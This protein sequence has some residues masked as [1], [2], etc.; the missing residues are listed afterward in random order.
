MWSLRL[1]SI[2][3]ALI[4]G[5]LSSLSPAA[6]A[7][8]CVSPAA[9][10]ATVR[11]PQAQVTEKADI[12]QLEPGEIVEREIAGGDQH[13]YR[14]VLTT[15][16][17]A[18][19]LITKQGTDI[20]LTWKSP[21]EETLFTVDLE[22]REHGVERISLL[23]K[24]DGP[25]TLVIEPVVKRYPR[26]H[27]QVKLD[28]LHQASEQD[29]QRFTAQEAFIEA[30]QR[31][32]KET[33]EAQGEA[34][35]KLA[36]ALALFQTIGDREWEARVAYWMGYIKSPLNKHKEAF[37][38]L[39]RAL[40][41][42]RA[43]G[44]TTGV[45]ETL[46][47]IGMVNL[48]LSKPP[49]ALEYFKQALDLQKS[50]A[51]RG[52][53][54]FTYSQLG[55]VYWMMGD[56]DKVGD[57]FEQGLQLLRELGNA[58]DESRMLASLSFIHMTQGNYLTGLEY[59]PPALALFRE[60]KDLEGEA[61]ALNSLGTIYYNLGEWEEKA[62]VYFNQSLICYEALQYPRNQAYVLTNLGITYSTLGQ[63]EKELARSGKALELKQ[64]ALEYFDRALQLTRKVNNARGE[65]NLLRHIGQVHQEMGNWPAALNHFNQTLEL[66]RK[67]SDPSTEARALKGIGEVYAAQG[68]R[69]K[70]LEGI[71]RALIIQR[72]I[73]ERSAVART[74]YSLARL[75]RDFGKLR[76]AQ[77]QIEEALDI[78]ESL[79][80]NVPSSNLRISFLAENQGFYDFYIDIL[81]RLDGQ[82]PNSG[83][84]ALALQASERAR[85]KALLESLAEARVDI[86]QGIAPALLARERDIHQQLNAKENNRIRLESRNA[87]PE[88]ITAADQDV[89]A[90]LDALH[91]VQAQ[92]RRTSP[93]Y[94]AITQPQPIDLKE[95]QA[96]LDAGTLLLV[97][98]LGANRS[99][100]WAVT[101][102]TLNSYELPESSHRINRYATEIADMIYQQQPEM[103][104]KL[105]V[106]KISRLLL[107]PVA[108]QLA[109][110]RLVIV[111]DGALQKLPFAALFAPGSKRRLIVEH[112]VINLPSVSVLV[113]LRQPWKERVSPE[114]TLV[115]IADPV[116][117]PEDVRFQQLKAAD[118]RGPSPYSNPLWAAQRAAQDVGLK[119][120]PRLEHSGREAEQI[121]KFIPPGE[122]VKYLGFDAS[123]ALLANP[124]LSKYR[125]LHFATH[126]VNNDKNPELSGIVLSLY[127]KEGRPQDGFLRM[128][129][130]YN[131]KLGAEM[132]VLSACK[133]G[134]GKQIRGEGSINLTRGIM[135]AGVPRIIVSLWNVNDAATAEL[136]KRF[137]EK[138][139]REKLSPAAA[140]RAAQVAMAHEDKWKAPYYWAGFVLQGEWR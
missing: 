106:E 5:P 61:A 130:F 99:F 112:E 100:L 68:D 28:D 123:R 7:R 72:R 3:I 129:E 140:L 122:Y 108:G 16:Q 79:R 71:D 126:S 73:K 9:P 111:A 47:T 137:Y 138:M 55:A 67:Q 70:A 62:L 98:R 63:R 85:A 29:R 30:V 75:E 21:T 69:Q 125:I 114:K 44:D 50:S 37:D 121:S 118:A 4:A 120:F 97:Y 94:A 13:Q 43:D 109:G 81:M 31:Y 76:E 14:L 96:Q 101:S 107:G 78:I 102:T 86:R 84:N 74:L 132:V 34:L 42:R 57:Y 51:E 2:L 87:T 56:I 80:A 104:T 53:L 52:Q 45:A 24:S 35:K 23:A 25:H 27:Y 139:L 46:R 49:Q 41:L 93:R 8:P 117:Q 113:Q 10:A 6:A 66:A 36:E 82:F 26:G 110:K 105:A 59:L 77:T 18:S 1:I 103:Q 83:Y 20:T 15:G 136:M 115:V 128:H 92:I 133:T 38:H 32:N 33:A 65:A 39:D 91:E 12:R 135:Y 17:Y 116:F 48:A 19:L 90:A 88:Q 134:V 131:I 60:I 54:A 11:N 40:E 64:K 89:R 58:R 95:V 119:E 127:D 124:D 22:Q